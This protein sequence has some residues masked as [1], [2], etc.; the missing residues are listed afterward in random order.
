MPNISTESTIAAS[1]DCDRLRVRVD[2]LKE[3]QTLFA[4]ADDTLVGVLVYSR[5]DAACLAVIH[6]AVAEDYS[7]R[8]RFAQQ[9]L[10]MR[11]VEVLRSNARRIKGIETVR[12]LYGGNR[13]RDFSV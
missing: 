8:G 3:V 6:L 5:I 4:L 2:K 12:L 11:M 7:T 10:V 1:A 13:V 9:M